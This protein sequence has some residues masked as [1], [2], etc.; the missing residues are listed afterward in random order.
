[1][2]RKAPGSIGGAN[3]TGGA[4]VAARLVWSVKHVSHYLLCSSITVPEGSV[5]R[6]ARNG[7]VLMTFL[8]ALTLGKISLDRGRPHYLSYRKLPDLLESLEREVA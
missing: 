1:M 3:M 8:E 2:L 6:L 5:P 4:A 7:E